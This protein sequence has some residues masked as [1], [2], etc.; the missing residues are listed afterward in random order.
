M[1]TKKRTLAGRCSAAGTAGLGGRCPPRC[2]AAGPSAV[3]DLTTFR[4]QCR[5]SVEISAENFRREIPLIMTT[6]E[7][8]EGEG[9]GVLSHPTCGMQTG[10][11]GVQLICAN[12]TDNVHLYRVV[13]DELPF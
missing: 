8:R 3:G 2:P 13:I 10:K 12:D 4:L 7:Q 6:A 11:L 9:A 5:G 1:R